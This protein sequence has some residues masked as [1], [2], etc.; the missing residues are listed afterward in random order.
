M[1][2]WIITTVTEAAF[3]LFVIV[4]LLFGFLKE[5]LEKR[6]RKHLSAKKTGTMQHNGVFF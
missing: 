3:V 5:E 6:S 4:L 1:I 2:F